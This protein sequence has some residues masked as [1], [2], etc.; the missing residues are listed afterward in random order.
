M[1]NPIRLQIES[2]SVPSMARVMA[3]RRRAARQHAHWTTSAETQH[4]RY[5]DV[6]AV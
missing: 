3:V 1:E 4:A 6:G 2:P 5:N